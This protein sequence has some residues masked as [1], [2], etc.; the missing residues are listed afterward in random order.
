M[1]HIILLG[2]LMLLPCGFA[3]PVAQKSLLTKLLDPKIVKKY[4][5]SYYV[6]KWKKPVI[7]DTAILLKEMQKFFQIKITGILDPETVEIMKQPRCGMPDVSEYSTFEGKPKWKKN[8]L[9]YRV[10]NTTSDLSRKQVLSDTAK[11]FKL[12][13]DVT[14]LKFTRTTG[15]ADIEM[16]FASDEHGDSYPFDGKDGTL[17]HAYAPGEGLGGDA[18]FDNDEKWSSSNRGTNFFT[19][20]AHEVGHSLGMDHSNVRGALMYPTYQYINKRNYRLPEDDKKGI[21][22]LYGKRT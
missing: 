17:A 22:S 21:Q 9:T 6:P 4:L 8:S 7:H 11:A 12:W 19:V 18:H 20:V 1:R 5:E 3:P 15:P 10:I 2:F 14:P 16:F 13:S